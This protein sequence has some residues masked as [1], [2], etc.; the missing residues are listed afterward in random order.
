MSS[1][2][3]I[4]ILYPLICGLVNIPR[5]RLVVFPDTPEAQPMDSL[6][7]SAVTQFIQIMVSLMQLK[8]F[9]ELNVIFFTA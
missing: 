3:E 1:H 7:D 6:V 4:Y 5:L 2:T 8:L 9:L